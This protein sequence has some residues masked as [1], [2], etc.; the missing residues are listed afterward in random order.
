M[1]L[2]LGNLLDERELGLT[3]VTSDA[4]ARE[5]PVRGAHAIEVAAPSRWI[6]ADWVMLTNGLRVRGRGDDQR[7]LIA[8]LD[9]GGQTAL[10]WAVGLVLQRVPQAIVDEAEQRGFPVFLVP[11]E[12]A[13]H[14]I[15]SFLHDARTSDDM[16]LMRRI[17]SMEDYLMDALQQ[18]RPEQA[19][20]SRLASLLDVDALLAT[21]GGEVVAASGALPAEDDLRAAIGAADEGVHVALGGRP[22]AV[23]P[24]PGELAGD[25]VLVVSGRR[26][27]TGDPLG[28]PV[29][30]RAAQLLGLVAQGR[31]HR[32]EHARA[33][34]AELLR[35]ALR[36]VAPAQAAGLDAEAAGLGVDFGAPAH[37]VAFSVPP[38]VASETAALALVRELVEGEGLHCLLCAV[39]EQPVALVQEEPARLAE[40]L[41]GA[42]ARGGR[43]LPIAGVGRQIGSLL[44]GRRSLR[45]ARLALAQARATGAPPGTVV[46]F[47]QLD[48][49]SQLLAT[50]AGADGG[51]GLHQLAGLLDPLRDQPHLLATLRTWIDCGQNASETAAHLHLHRNSLRYRLARIEELLGVVLE[52]PRGLAN[53]QLALLADELEAGGENA[54]A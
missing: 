11:I 51:D 44:D 16:V 15:I 42:A 23:V 52:T 19:I 34:G 40:A 4:S 25:H 20:V 28:R 3:L 33:R 31:A 2:T 18:R 6:P 39:G 48:P 46:R 49:V 21:S 29:A 36:G 8:E 13:F 54:A 32:E 30:R 53:V 43:P 47:D 35:R 9:E 22:T 12:T 5:R 10:G 7:R 45:D 38:G 27:E 41:A 26:A 50:A 24:V 14:Q 1:Q 17:M 37:V